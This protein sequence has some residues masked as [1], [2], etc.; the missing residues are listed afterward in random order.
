MLSRKVDPLV[1]VL[2][3][4]HAKEREYFFKFYWNTEEDF[5]EH[6]EFPRKILAAPPASAIIIGKKKT[7][8]NKQNKTQK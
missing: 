4:R 8:N 7:K 5:S 3:R 6:F 2:T 1:S